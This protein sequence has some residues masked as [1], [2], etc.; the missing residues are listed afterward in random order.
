MADFETKP[1]AHAET[2]AGDRSAAELD[3]MVP[4]Y[5][6]RLRPERGA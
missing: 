6:Q 2:M 5:R 1:M 4:L 3:S